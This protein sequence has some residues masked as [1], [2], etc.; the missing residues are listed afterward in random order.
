APERDQ[1]FVAAQTVAFLRQP[2]PDWPARSLDRHGKRAVVD[3][4]RPY[5]RDAAD[6]L[7]RL[8][9]DQR[10]AAGRSR[11]S[12]GPVVY[13]RERVQHLEEVDE[14]GNEQALPEAA[15]GE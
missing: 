1:R 6:G 10:T 9:R 12:A 13:G 4:L 5:R 8:A 11:D 3:Q 7:E 14:R 15:A 2:D